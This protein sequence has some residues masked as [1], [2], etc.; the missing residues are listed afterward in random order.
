MFKTK[1]NKCALYVI[2]THLKH[3]K[4]NI[5][6]DIVMLLPCVAVNSIFARAHIARYF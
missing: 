4:S 2:S 6:H 5:F 1:N 3:Y